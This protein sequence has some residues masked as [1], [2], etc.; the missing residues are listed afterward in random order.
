MRPV[1]VTANAAGTTVIP[2]EWR[3]HPFQVTLT[4]VVSGTLTFEVDWT[5]DNVFTVASGSVN[6]VAGA[7]NMGLAS[8]STTT[9]G[10]VQNPVFAI[11]LNVT[12]FTSGS[13]VLTVMQ[14]GSTG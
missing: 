6:W 9:N 7:A 10:T 3:Q 8:G 12:A 1:I 2:L 4:A 5:L 14:A 11:R 13:V